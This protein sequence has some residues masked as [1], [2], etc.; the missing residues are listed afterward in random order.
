[1][2]EQIQSSIWIHK[3]LMVKAPQQKQEPRRWPVV[4]EMRSGS[5]KRHGY[6]PWFWVLWRELLVEQKP[7]GKQ[8]IYMEENGGMG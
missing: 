4:S 6:Y 5:C 7:D 3:V 1:M 8:E 2:E